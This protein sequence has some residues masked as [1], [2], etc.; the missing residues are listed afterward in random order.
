MQVLQQV[1]FVAKPVHRL[2]ASQCRL[3]RF[4]CQVTT[5]EQEESEYMPMVGFCVFCMLGELTTSF[6]TLPYFPNISLL[7]RWLSEY[8]LAGMPTMY[9]R[10]R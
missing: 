3:F 8:S 4:V 9:A 1:T 6:C 7:R 5:V 10:L 2:D